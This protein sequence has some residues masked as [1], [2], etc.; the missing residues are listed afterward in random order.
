MHSIIYQS[1]STLIALRRADQ[2]KR[3]CFM[4]ALDLLAFGL[5]C[6]SYAL[7]TMACMTA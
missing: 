3:R 7:F 1:P 5:M 4:S 6:L 2:K